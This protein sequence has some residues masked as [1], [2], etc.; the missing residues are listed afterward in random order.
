MKI[1]II[2]DELLSLNRLK[3]LLNEAG[4]Q[5]IYQASDGE[6]ALD[7]LEKEPLIDLVFIDIIMPGMSGV[8]L[9]YRILMK[10]HDIFI[11]FQTAFENYA[12]EAF[13]IGAIDYLLKPYTLEDIK[14]VL[15]RVEKFRSSIK[16]TKFMVKTLD[17]NYKIITPEDIFYIKAELKD[18]MLRTAT[19]YIYYPISISKLEERLKIHDFFRIH[20]S[21]LINLSKIESIHT[22]EQ[23]KLLFKFKDINDSIISSKE[24]GKVFRE[25]FKGTLLRE[26]IKP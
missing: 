2:D 13:K 12:I 10:K 1:L 19:D 24:G 5:S 8:D 22:I 7:I 21:Y 25:K 3:R 11:V 14:R 26:N 20:K 6:S 17:G 23:S 15:N 16:S 18:S 9:A 4:E